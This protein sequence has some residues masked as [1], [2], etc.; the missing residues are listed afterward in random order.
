MTQKAT[1]TTEVIAALLEQRQTLGDDACDV[2]FRFYYPGLVRFATRQGAA[3]AEAAASTALLDAFRAF[4]RSPIRSE[5]AFRAYAHKATR[6]AGMQQHRRRRPEPTDRLDI[7]ASLPDAGD[8]VAERQWLAELVGALPPDQQRVVEARFHQDLTAEEA[9]DRLGRSA[10]A[11]HQLQHRAITNLRRA[12]LA[13]A[14]IALIV[15]AVLFGRYLLTLERLE[16][17]PAD[18]RP[19]PTSLPAPE[20]TDDVETPTPD[21]SA[22]PTTEAT[23]G[24]VES[25]GSDEPGDQV[26][27][28]ERS[29]AVAELASFV[30]NTAVAAD[31]PDGTYDG[32][33]TVAGERLP[34]TTSK[35]TAADGAVTLSVALDEPLEAGETAPV[36]TVTLSAATFAAVLD[37]SLT[38]AEALEADGTVV[39]ES[40]PE[41]DP[42]RPTDDP[43]IEQL[44]LQTLSTAAFQPLDDGTYTGT[45]SIDGARREAV[46][47]KETLA[48][49]R[50]RLTRET[51]DGDPRL[52]VAITL[53]A[54]VYRRLLAGEQTPRTTLNE[55]STVV[56]TA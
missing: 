19:G 8:T 9:G 20:T 27:P 41:R 42:T 43:T 6:H 37:G 38:T 53:Q 51:T 11:V 7:G 56:A 12:V 46:L 50:I 4:D 33:A 40:A 52:V 10:N 24:D 44:A 26:E 13:A 1:P 14:A 49:G 25:D 55:V 45:A 47:V 5:A 16:T 36:V 28:G 32:T 48:D 29:A 39:E 54:D 30:I 17:G 35:R 23:S 2:L 18:D 15:A 31:Q 34:A 22:P 21:T 3:D